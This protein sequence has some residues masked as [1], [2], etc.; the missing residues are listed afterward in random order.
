MNTLSLWLRCFKCWKHFSI[1]KIECFNFKIVI[2][3]LFIKYNNGHQLIG[4]F[5]IIA[6][7]TDNTWQSCTADVTFVAMVMSD[8]VLKFYE[9]LHYLLDSWM[10][11]H[12]VNTYQ[13]IFRALFWFWDKVLAATAWFRAAIDQIILWLTWLLCK[14]DTMLNSIII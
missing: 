3:I 14:Y 6:G 13:V 1:L 12:S 9:K 5:F 7:K 10:F 2:T 4:H 11:T 8:S